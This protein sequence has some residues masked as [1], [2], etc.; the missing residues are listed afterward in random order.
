[1]AVLGGRIL[2]SER[3][4]GSITIAQPRWWTHWSNQLTILRETNTASAATARQ[5]YDAGNNNH[6]SRSKVFN[7]IRPPSQASNRWS[8]KAIQTKYSSSYMWKKFTG[9]YFLAL[10]NSLSTS[11]ASCGIIMRGMVGTYLL[12]QFRA[13]ILHKL[14]STT[15]PL[16]R[17]NRSGWGEAHCCVKISSLKGLVLTTK[18]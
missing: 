3:N 8:S 17:W 18:G 4:A 16:K 10:Q 12:A 11:K 6:Q 2:E 14:G 9:F 7:W 13:R 15:Q 1:M 5:G